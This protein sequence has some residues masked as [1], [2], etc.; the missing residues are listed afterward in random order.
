MYLYVNSEENPQ[1][2][3][4]YIEIFSSVEATGFEPILLSSWQHR[5][6][7]VRRL[8]HW[9]DGVAKWQ[10]YWFK[11]SHPHAAGYT[12]V[13]R[14]KTEDSHRWWHPN[15]YILPCCSPCYP[16]IIILYQNMQWPYLD[17]I[18][19]CKKCAPLNSESMLTEGNI[20]FWKFNC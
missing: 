12:N 19:D 11:S 15:I 20:Q 10:K 8:R 5:L 2:E 13:N 7:N 1:F 6:L 3:S 14:I 16:S 4:I 17:C 18:S 9:E